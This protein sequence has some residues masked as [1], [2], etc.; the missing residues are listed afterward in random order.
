MF[1]IPAAKEFT[2]PETNPGSPYSKAVSA[3]KEYLEHDAVNALIGWAGASPAPATPE[4]AAGVKPPGELPAAPSLNLADLDPLAEARQSSGVL[5]LFLA[6]TTLVKGATRRIALVASTP[7][8][9]VGTRPYDGSGDPPFYEK[10]QLDEYVRRVALSAVGQGVDLVCVSSTSAL[11]DTV[12]QVDT[13]SRP[14]FVARVEHNLNRLHA[15]AELPG[16][17]CSFRWSD[18]LPMTFLVVDDHFMIW[19]KTTNG[20]TGAK[21]TTWLTAQSEL[22]ANALYEKATSTGEQRSLA[23]VL[24]AIGL[25]GSGHLSG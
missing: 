9:V 18:P 5:S 20:T 21:E 6:G 24:D 1:Y 17:R 3:M 25:A 22:L 19:M 14:A 16:A 23:Q 8:L 11:R 2:A 10:E 15:L 4:P 13:A 12:G 7:I